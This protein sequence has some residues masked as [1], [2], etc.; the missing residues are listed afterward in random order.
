[1]TF[2]KVM[3]KE[4]PVVIVARNLE[5]PSEMVAAAKKQILSCFNHGKQPV[6]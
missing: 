2:K 6:V 3:A 1:M 5:I 4:T